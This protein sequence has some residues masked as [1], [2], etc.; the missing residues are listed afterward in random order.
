MALRG[1]ALQR[2]AHFLPAF[3]GAWISSAQP[4]LGAATFIEPA[5]MRLPTGQKLLDNLRVF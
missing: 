4:G 1:A 3:A 5:L 2:A